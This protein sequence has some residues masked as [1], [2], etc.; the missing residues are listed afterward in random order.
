MNNNFYI[1]IY[2]YYFHIFLYTY[3]QTFNYKIPFITTAYPFGEPEFTP[4]SLGFMY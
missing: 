4:I 3:L 1:T 2:I